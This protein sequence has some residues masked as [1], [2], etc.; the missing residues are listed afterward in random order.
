MTANK[1][2]DVLLQAGTDL[3]SI[4]LENHD[5]EIKQQCDELTDAMAMG[6]AGLLLAIDNGLDGDAEGVTMN[7]GNNDD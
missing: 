4:M 6:I 2:I 7:G 5:A 3:A 1:A